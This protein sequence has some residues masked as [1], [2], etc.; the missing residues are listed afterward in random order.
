MRPGIDF[1]CEKH[2]DETYISRYF[3]T[4]MPDGSVNLIERGRLLLKK[5]A[6]PSIFSDLPC[7]TMNKPTKKKIAEQ[8]IC[9]IETISSSIDNISKIHANLQNTLKNMKLP[10]DWFFCYAHSS[11]VLGY[12]DS[13]HE[14]IKRIIIS[15]KDLH[16]KVWF[17]TTN[18]NNNIYYNL[19]YI[20]GIH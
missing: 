7:L 18:I 19:Q 3:E 14:L 8:N 6:I 1:V 13:N 16:L 17:L 5:N 4:K 9:S 10:D 12:L 11:L 15:N 20:S 2:F